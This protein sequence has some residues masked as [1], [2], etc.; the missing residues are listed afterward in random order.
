MEISGDVERNFEDE[1]E[2]IG[3]KVVRRR[4]QLFS[5]HGI[6]HR[7]RTFSSELALHKVDRDT[8]ILVYTPAGQEVANNARMTIRARGSRI[9]GGSGSAEAKETVKI[10]LNRLSEA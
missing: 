3:K 5:K 7:D 1:G 8:I 2:G 6:H 9:M 4:Q 10:R